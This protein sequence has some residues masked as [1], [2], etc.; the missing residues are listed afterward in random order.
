MSGWLRYAIVVLVVLGG[1]VVPAVVADQEA[2]G[3]S[4]TR[5]RVYHIS[6]LIGS[7]IDVERFIERVVTEVGEH[8]EWS[9]NGGDISFIDELNDRLF[10]K[11][12]VANHAVIDHMIT[13]LRKALKPSVVY[14]GVYEP[15]YPG[16]TRSYPIKKLIKPRQWIEH[17][18]HWSADAE[19]EGPFT[20]REA[21]EDIENLL[22]ETVGDYGD[23]VHQGG[24][25]SE[26]DDGPEGL[27]I[28]TSDANHKQIERLLRDIVPTFNASVRI[29]VRCLIVPEEQLEHTGIDIDLRA[30]SEDDERPLGFAYLESET[31]EKL[32]EK[33]RGLSDAATMTL[34]AMEV[35][36]REKTYLD[37]GE[38]EK[39][40]AWFKEVPTVGPDGEVVDEFG[41][42]FIP[43]F[44][45][46]EEGLIFAVNVRD[47]VDGSYIEATI[48]PTLLNVAE[49]IPKVA[50]WRGNEADEASSLVEKPEV[51]VLDVEL[52]L[53]I[54]DGTW[55]VM[56]MGSTK[57]PIGKTDLPDEVD[58]SLERRVWVLVRSKIVGSGNGREE[59]A[60]R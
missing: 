7:S 59:G 1:G 58:E 43:L 21:F 55:F 38:K 60:N 32:Y 20:W 22:G 8:D 19:P 27:L 6:D 26:I 44:R 39:Y 36:Y 54:P 9:I 13:D 40:L 53:S 17:P 31:A 30:I 42:T 57:G 47:I 4:E 25:I 28:S 11:T 41:G 2:A 18:F 34:P 49:P 35:M 23:W 33:V 45:T 29:D 24:D 10:V 16:Q 37:W 3:E 46:R 48:R 12:T 14:R 51:S 52:S 50:A 5:T 56:D 15:T